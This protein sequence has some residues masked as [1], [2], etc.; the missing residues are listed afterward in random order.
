MNKFSK[1]IAAGT[2]FVTLGLGA[3]A[4]HAAD[5]TATASAEILEQVSVAFVSNLEFGSIVPDDTSDVD[6]S[7]AA[8]SGATVDCGTLTC[9]GTSGPASWTVSGANLAVTVAE[10]VALT[11]LSTTGGDTMAI[12]LSLG[13][14]DLSGGSD[15]LYVGGTLTVGANQ[16]AGDY[17][18]NIDLTVDY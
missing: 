18:G 6:V 17:E 2:A 7:V 1:V 15:T 11:Q 13:S 16:A 8:A 9:N 14:V 3:G 10:D 4:A 12:A 5:A